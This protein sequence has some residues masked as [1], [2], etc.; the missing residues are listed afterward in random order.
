MTRQFAPRLR[1]FG[2]SRA[3]RR[4]LAE[5]PEQEETAGRKLAFLVGIKDYN[6]LELKN[7][8]FPEND[9]EEL[10]AVLKDQHFETVVL[11]TA[12]GKHDVKEQPTAANIRHQLKR[13]ARRH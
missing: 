3:D 11:T 12:R 6:H 5:G 10:A 2:G 4:V 1:D 7:L 13:S 9:V 8:D